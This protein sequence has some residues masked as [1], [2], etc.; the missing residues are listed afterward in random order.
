MN[1]P[2]HNSIIK[3]PI[4]HATG[5]AAMGTEHLHPVSFPALEDLKLLAV[6]PFEQRLG[7]HTLAASSAQSSLQIPPS[8][9]QDSSIM[10][11]TA[12]SIPLLLLLPRLL[13]PVNLLFGLFTV[14]R[15]RPPCP[16]ESFPAGEEITWL[17][18][19]PSAMTAKARSNV[20]KKA[21]EEENMYFVF[22]VV[23]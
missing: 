20:T 13:E 16:T 21:R 10:K 23:N 14:R 11:H 1:V 17:F 5:G 15:R 22:I 2:V 18:L 9:A 8:L 3:G 19:E 4:I 6:F 7:M 12:S